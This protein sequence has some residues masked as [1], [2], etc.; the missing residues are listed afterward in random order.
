MSP[1]RSF[2]ANASAF[3]SLIRDLTSKLC[4]AAIKNQRSKLK[5]QRGKMALRLFF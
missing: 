5:H 1:K 4:I 3:V 2:Y